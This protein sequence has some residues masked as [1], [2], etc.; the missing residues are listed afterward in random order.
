MKFYFTIICFCLLFNCTQNASAQIVLENSYD[1]ASYSLSYV[2]L[3]HNGEKYVAIRHSNFSSAYQSMKFYNLNHSIW[4]TINLSSLPIITGPF[5]GSSRA[6]L[7]VSDSLFAT[8]TLIE[9]MYSISYGDTIP[10]S[11]G[12]AVFSNMYTYIYNE[13][14]TSIFSDNVGL[15]NGNY[16][17]FPEEK[18][19]IINTTQGTKMILNST[20]PLFQA[21]VYSLPGIYIN[22]NKSYVLDQAQVP[23]SAE[24]MNIYPNPSSDYTIVSYSLP[25]DVE[26][27]KMVFYDLNGKMVKSFTIDHTFTNL[28]LSVYDL[29]TGS[30]YCQV[31]G[32]NRV[33]SGKK[34]IKIN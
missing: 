21:K 7:F 3:Q 31:E 29:N 30:Y 22:A 26:T 17:G 34:L 10:G 2:R 27:A 23:E 6:I 18:W 32:E 20:Y 4:K 12:G 16:S 11:G 1:T 8:D 9:F 25:K 15:Y 14:L 13:N 5:G 24:K 28:R 19:P 33:L